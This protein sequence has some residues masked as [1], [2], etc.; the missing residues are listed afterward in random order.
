M[1]DRRSIT[2]V[3][4]RAVPL[5]PVHVG[6]GQSIRL[7]EYFIDA[8]TASPTADDDD[9]D[10]GTV[11]AAGPASLCH[12]DQG[13]AL[14]AMPPGRRDQFRRYLD[15]GN[16]AEASPLLR[17]AGRDAI[18]ERI[19]LSDASRDALSQAIKDPRSRSG[20]VHMFVRSGGR[21]FIPGSSIKG[22]FRTA[23]ASHRLPTSVAARGL[24]HQSAMQAALEI[25]QTDT[26]S[27]P[28]RHLSISDAE[29]PEGATRIDRTEI[30][31][32]GGGPASTNGRGGIQMHY[33]RLCARS[34]RPGDKSAF[35][36]SLRL[37]AR[38]KIGRGDLLQL[39]SRYHWEIWRKER[40]LFFQT[41]PKSV[42][43]VDR[44]LRGAKGNDGRPLSDAGP[45][46]PNYLLLRLGRF[47]HFESKS[48]ARVRQGEF[49]QARNRDER[50]RQPDTWG[51]T[52]TVIRN[53]DGAPIPFGWVLA[54]VEKED[55]L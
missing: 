41:Q 10:G 4:L 43:A 47:G 22:A 12:F 53:A 15:L 42:D 33:E 21:P 39:V 30:V 1:S 17:E 49:P 52:R 6:D 32:R 5:T 7:D 28:L 2:R 44:F 20:G 3:T 37:D 35:G 48:L 16:L 54:W 38:L 23:L 9:T 13:Q 40:E 27:D 24:T 25:D 45:I 11:A 51:S 14:R 36:F 31:K 46:A 26:A 8:P 55:A 29:L 34:D 18:A 50:I 19:A